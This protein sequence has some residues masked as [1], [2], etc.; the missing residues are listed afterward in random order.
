MHPE[1]F[2]VRLYPVFLGLGIATG[3]AVT[4]CS[5]RRIGVPWGRLSALLA[6]LCLGAL[7]GAKVHAGI[8]GGGGWP[9]ITNLSRGFRH[10]GG[11]LGLVVALPLARRLL[12]VHL[13]VA[14]L[15]DPLA[16]AAGVAMA[17]VRLGCFLAGCCHGGP[18]TLPWAVRFPAHS[19]AWEGQVAG[20]L[21]A[22]D[23][24]QSLPVHPLQLYF[25]LTALLATLVAL[26]VRR[27]QRDPGQVALSFVAADNTAR[28]L[29]EF[30]RAEPVPH[31]CWLAAGIG[32]AA[33]AG[34]LLMS[35]RR[36]RTRAGV[37]AA[38]G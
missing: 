33:T 20:G 23:A 12:H 36:R 6:L 21:L 24:P 18:S 16:P 19:F 34:L 9:G 31:L 32:G 4:L 14:A 7:A 13:S 37:Q 30:L 11:M 28:F 17:L 15:A 3:T 1:L 27:S 22:N 8:E 2:G 10:P 5:A 29:L 38:S 26:R 25:A 35:V